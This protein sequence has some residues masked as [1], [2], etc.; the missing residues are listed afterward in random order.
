MRTAQKYG[1][2]LQAFSLKRMSNTRACDII[3]QV[4]FYL[5]KEGLSYNLEGGE[6]E[7]P[8]EGFIFD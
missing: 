7:Y 8:K 4:C 1:M 5:E 6:I 3:Q 2:P